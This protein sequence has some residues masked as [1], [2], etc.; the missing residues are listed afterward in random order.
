MLP[1]DLRDL[2]ADEIGALRD[3]A[4]ASA[5]PANAARMLNHLGGELVREG[6]IAEAIEVYEQALA[7]NRGINNRNSEGITLS[8][9]GSAYRQRGSFHRALELMEQALSIH[10]EVG[11]RK[12]EG[13]DL[14]NIADL[15]ERLGRPEDGLPHMERAL[16][17]LRHEAS[18][19]DLATTLNNLGKMLHK[20]GRDQEAQA[21]LDRAVQAHHQAGNRAGEAMAL[22]NLGSY[23][24]SQGETGQSIQHFQRA[25]ALSR[26][27][28]DRRMEARTLNNLG[29]VYRTLGRLPQ[30]VQYI[31][32]ARQLLCELGDRE[33]EVFVC[34]LLGDIQMQLRRRNQ[35]R[36]LYERAIDLA[37]SLRGEILSEELRTSFFTTVSDA[38]A[39]YVRVLVEQGEAEEAL[40]A[41]ETGRARGF[42][43]LLAD[44]QADVRKGCDPAL[45]AAEAS[46]LRS[47]R[48]V[49]RLLT[50]ARSAP[51]A[52]REAGR[53]ESLSERERELERA[54]YAHQAEVR[55]K[56]PRYAAL[57]QA[58]VWTPEAIRQ[59]LLGG[60]TA[61]LEYTLGDQG[62]ALVVALADRTAA[63]RLPPRQE[64]ETQV[65]ELWMAVALE[66]M[67]RYPHGHDLYQT[68]IAPA[69]EL[70]QGKDLLIVADGALH[71]LPF[72]LLLTEP[73]R[74][75]AAGA[76]AERP[77]PPVRGAGTWVTERSELRRS[78]ANLPAF[79]FPNLS[80]LIRRHAIR[81][82]PSATVAGLLKDEAGRRKGVAYAGEFAALGNPQVEGIEISLEGAPA[83]ASGPSLDEVFRES[84]GPLQPIPKTEDE[85]WQVARLFSSV[86]ERSPYQLKYQDDR[87]WLRLGAEAT[88]DAL[89]DLLAAPA[90]YRYLH[91]ATHGLI[92]PRK[93]EY[94]GLVLSPG[95]G[96]GSFWQV[97]DILNT[98][99]SSEMVVLSACDT[100]LGRLH[101]G[102]G[103]IGLTRAFLHAGAS[104]L[105][106][107]LWKVA[108]DST[109]LLMEHFYRALTAGASKSQALREAQLALIDSSPFVHPFYWAPFILV[110]DAG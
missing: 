10:R 29:A 79:Q 27:A 72:A 6:R 42:L 65:M 24:D 67:H 91:L 75:G 3:S 25:L 104:S 101:R 68:L 8:N 35:A 69:E 45:K 7:I 87:V 33:G 46:A 106:V 1:S 5:D 84:T 41:A 78:Q 96:R 95:P 48:D 15:Y 20:A 55:R 17:L 93:P 76:A 36:Q 49:R 86:V 50:E 63:F 14:N 21:Y 9:L 80:Y 59:S 57:T 105:C 23:Y 4:R 12:A 71:F 98:A 66:G 62:S 97:F 108:D 43:D 83:A 51:A 38:Y 11:N 82:A 60:G 102:E 32:Q 2:T 70:I 54:Y 58:Q 28:G 89:G 64:I 19:G 77:S 18:E 47:L 37:E 73:P 44:A 16:E 31:E 52:D 94:S 61:L 88:L 103:M 53:L 90:G 100:G 40:S 110:G 107:S 22:N 26:V 30:A 39:G 99:I 13:I 34:S 74:D 81:Y 92:N 85:V 109:P 56:N